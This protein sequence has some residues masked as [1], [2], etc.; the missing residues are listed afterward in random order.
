MADF[1]KS[2]GP[3]EFYDIAQKIYNQW[4]QD[5]K[6]STQIDSICKS[7]DKLKLDRLAK[8]MQK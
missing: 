4:S 6:S 1:M 2:L 5:N 8:I 7:D 3:N